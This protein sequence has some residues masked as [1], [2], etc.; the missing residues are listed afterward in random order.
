MPADRRPLRDGPYRVRL[1]PTSEPVLREKRDGLWYEPGSDEPVRLHA[2]CSPG[3]H[4][5]DRL[6]AEILPAEGSA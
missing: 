4:V 3:R 2:S 6:Y 1:F 5:S